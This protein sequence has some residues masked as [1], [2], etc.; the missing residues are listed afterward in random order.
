MYQLKNVR[1][2]AL[3]HRLAELNALGNRTTAELLAHIAEVDD[4]HLHLRM[5]YASM[6]AYCVTELHMS[7]ASARRRVHAAHTARAF[8]ALF[9]AIA[10][11][12]L[13][14]TAIALLSARMTTMNV[15]ELIAAA[16]HKTVGEIERLLVERW[17]QAEELDFDGGV[18]SQV[19]APQRANVDTRF[20]KSAFPSGS[21]A[22]AA[23]TRP[24]VEALSAERFAVQVSI[25][26]PTYDKL[27]RAQDL[28]SHALPSRDV[29]DVF[30][31]ALDALLEKLEKRKVG[32]GSRRSRRTVS[33]RMIQ[34]KVKRAVWDRDGGCCSLVGEGGRPCRSTD[35]VEFD[36]IKPVA[37]GGE[38]TV[39]NVRLLCRAHNQFAAEEALGRKFMDERRK[40]RLMPVG[41]LHEFEK[42]G[43]RGPRSQNDRPA[44]NGDGPHFDGVHDDIEARSTGADFECSEGQVLEGA[45][46][47]RVRDGR[48]A[49][50]GDLYGRG[51][52]RVTRS[53]GHRCVD[54]AFGSGRKGCRICPS[55]ELEARKLRAS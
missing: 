18:R 11:G 25:A 38:S 22:S 10:D 1:D 27:C 44:E 21:Q 41:S 50:A 16:T 9:P 33:S 26:R 19:V 49:A 20:L 53:V 7:E 35:Q 28:L 37:M 36:H 46:P 34:A 47:E 30:D 23:P 17:P 43:P 13:H 5:G 45:P 29:A 8:P 55:G 54:R 6:A 40:R 31:R 39:E 12:R 42:R 24:R 51:D 4:R 32:S 14:L 2:E 3:L 48:S 15:D 52:Q